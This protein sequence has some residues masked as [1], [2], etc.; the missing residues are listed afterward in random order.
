MDVYQPGDHGS[1]FG[2]NPLGAAVGRAS[3][4]VVIEE[5]LSQRSDEL[6]S[7]FMEELRAIYS[8]HVE[9]VRGRGLMIGVL[10]KESSGTA[11]PYC[12]ALL[13]KGIL[14][15]ETHHQVIRFAPPLNIETAILE[16]AL[17]DIK[18]VLL[19]TSI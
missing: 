17:V 3:L 4:R 11:R 1:T 18:T 16:E 15:K 13:E 14:A 9:E 12:E 2:G 6:G 8:P 5:N 10:I 19:E 7:W